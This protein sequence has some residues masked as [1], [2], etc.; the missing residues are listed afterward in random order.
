MANTKNTIC[1]GS[2]QDAE[3]DEAMLDMRKI[4]DVAMAAARRGD[5]S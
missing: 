4:D 5:R 1:V 3:A 2:D